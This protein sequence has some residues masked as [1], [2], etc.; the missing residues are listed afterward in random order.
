MKTNPFGANLLMMYNLHLNGVL[1]ILK[2]GNFP[3]TGHFNTLDY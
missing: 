2:K 3:E 1:K